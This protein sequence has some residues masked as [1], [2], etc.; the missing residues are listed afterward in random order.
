MY[1][2]VQGTQDVVVVVPLMKRDGTMASRLNTVYMYTRVIGPS[3]A[4]V[5]G[6]TAP[7]IT[8]PNNDG[9]YVLVFPTTAP[10]AAFATADPNSPYTLVIGSSESNVIPMVVPIWINP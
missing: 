6:Y 8:E 9:I 2:P 7:T 3:G 4:Q 1:R 5:T 10:V